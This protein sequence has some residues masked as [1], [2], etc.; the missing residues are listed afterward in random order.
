MHIAFLNPQG[1]F[2]PTDR[3]WTEHPDFGGQLVY[4]K[5]LALALG[6]L[7]HRVDVITRQMTDAAWPE[8]AAA[9]D[10]YPGH[11][12]VRI[13]RMPCGPPGFL[14]KEDLWLHLHQWVDGALAFYEREGALPDATTGHYAD[15]GLTAAMIQERTSL[16]F[17]FT[18]HSLGAQKMDKIVQHPDDF[19]AA[20]A[21]YH[22]DKRLAAERVA[23][24]RAGCI[25]TSS[26][27]ERLEQY[28]HRLYRGAVD[29][30]EE[31][32]FAVVPPGVNLSVFGAEVRNGE[33]ETVA[34]R[35]E[36]M[37]R[38]DIPEAR[39]HL[40]LVISASRLDRKKN[41]L[42]TVEAWAV[43][44]AL[45]ESA[46]L[47]IIVR[48]NADPLRERSRAFNGE[49]LEI[50]HEIVDV[51]D[52]QALW[53]CLTAFDLNSQAELAA[54]YRYL[55]RHR[56]GV[57]CLT[58]SYEPFGL[59]PL[60]AMAAGLPVVVTQNGGP[61]ESL[62]DE[63]GRYGILVDPHDPHAIADGL[64][65]LTRDDAAWTTMQ[66]AGLQR[67]ADRYTW[68]RT[69]QGYLRAL[70]TIIE[71]KDAGSYPIPAYFQNAHHEDVDPAWLAEMYFGET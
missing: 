24:A 6:R 60:E 29:P 19:A 18:A 45:R 67:V 44:E 62:Q 42:A 49:A 65:C 39:R 13:L 52:E 50:L 25:V 46:N 5:E 68:T 54:C 41:H 37:L 7:G 31:D 55:A 48:G 66:Q 1:N 27:Q 59:A 22:F 23:I 11:P 34:A 64:T 28:G 32:A 51:V 10:G 71:N 17:T 8:F 53:P 2:D 21:Q 14:R 30:G 35:V 43:S 9:L 33:E 47:A 15:G 70:R 20:V 3:G 36:A 26:R 56:R 57:F 38:R 61:T 4:V 58:A 12:R 40:P 69:A 63:Q 16:P